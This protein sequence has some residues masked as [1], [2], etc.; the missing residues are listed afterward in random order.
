VKKS[1]VHKKSAWCN[2]WASTC[3]CVASRCPSVYLHKPLCSRGGL[4]CFFLTRTKPLP[5]MPLKLGGPTYP[6]SINGRWQLSS[7]LFLP[8]SFC[9]KQKGNSGKNS[10][11]EGFLSAH[12]PIFIISLTSILPHLPAVEMGSMGEW[13]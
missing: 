13:E 1:P 7:R 8:L 5:I 12:S 11:E 9:P 3:S 10:L 2:S 6:F 4:S